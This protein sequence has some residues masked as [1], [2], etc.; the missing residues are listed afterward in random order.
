MRNGEINYGKHLVISFNIISYGCAYHSI[1]ISSMG[2][3]TTQKQKV[4]IR[5]ELSCRYF[6]L[7]KCKEKASYN[8][9]QPKRA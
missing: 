6:F 5:Q 7:Q 2:R 4:N 1:W 8:I 9:L 3:K